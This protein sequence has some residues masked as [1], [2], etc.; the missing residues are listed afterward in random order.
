VLISEHH[1]CSGD[2]QRLPLPAPAEQTHTPRPVA[3]SAKAAGA[4]VER[5]DEVIEWESNVSYWSI[6]DMVIALSDVRFRRK[7]DIEI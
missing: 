3:K 2:R 4:G 1:A 5:A 7:A 6:A